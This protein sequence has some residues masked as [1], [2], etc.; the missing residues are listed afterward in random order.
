MEKSFFQS[1]TN[2]RFVLRKNEESFRETQTDHIIQKYYTF[3]W[4]TG[5][6]RNIIIDD[7]T[8]TFKRNAV[9]PIMMHQRF[10]C[11]LTE[12]II[13]IQFNREFYCIVNHDAEVGCVGFLF[14]GLS[15][16]VFIHPDLQTQKDLGY[17]VNSLERELAT[18]EANK[19]DMLRSLLVRT[20]ILLTRQAK[21]QYYPED[22]T[23]E[24]FK[25]VRHFNLLVELHYKQQHQVQFYADLLNKSS[26]TL[27]NSFSRYSKRSPQQ[28]IHDRITAEA[29]RLLMYTQKSIKEISG[30]LG[31]EDQA[32]FNKFFKNRTGKNPSALRGER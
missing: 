25:L 30:D 21:K 2:A 23:Q 16:I 11:E 20:I 5:K 14:Y 29:V 22:S 32:H 24:T 27:S 8:V 9:L 26:K 17:I 6:T 28:M 1:E 3:L 7:V 12:D 18:D 4:N 31:F 15:P 13:A 10:R 19:V